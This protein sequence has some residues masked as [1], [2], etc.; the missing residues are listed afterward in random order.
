M[1]ILI[2]KAEYNLYKNLPKYL[3]MI[4]LVVVWG[5]GSYRGNGGLFVPIAKTGGEKVSVPAGWRC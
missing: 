1:R 4:I 5:V 3:M 2:I